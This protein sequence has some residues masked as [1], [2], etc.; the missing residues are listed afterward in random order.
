MD[1]QPNHG[2]FPEFREIISVGRQYLAGDICFSYMNE[3][4]MRCKKATHFFSA[5]KELVEITGDWENMLHRC[6]NEWN[7]LPRDQE[8]TEEEL[9][10]WVANTLAVFE[11]SLIHI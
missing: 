3:S 1:L 2:L 8:I 6:W 5:H 9:Y 11:L 4:V 7:F 10:A